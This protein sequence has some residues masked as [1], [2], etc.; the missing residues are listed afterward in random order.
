MDRS[1]LSSY[2]MHDIKAVLYSITGLS[3]KMF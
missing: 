1:Q 3:V 2:S